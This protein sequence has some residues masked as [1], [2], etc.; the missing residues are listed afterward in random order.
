MSHVF[1]SCSPLYLLETAWSSPVQP[2]WLGQTG[3]P[4]AF[5]SLAMRF[6]YTPP[7]S[8]SYVCGKDPNSGPHASV[9]STLLIQSPSQFKQWLSKLRDLH[10]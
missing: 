9:S 7:H 4:P 8:T 1:L 6:W 3:H 5:A 2:A 10:K